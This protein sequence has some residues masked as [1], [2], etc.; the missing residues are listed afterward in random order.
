MFVIF[1]GLASIELPVSAYRKCRFPTIS[2]DEFNAAQQEGWRCV[3]IRGGAHD[4]L[5]LKP[6]ILIFFLQGHKLVKANQYELVTA[7]Q[8]RK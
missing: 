3:C 1:F 4:V 8:I 5:K 2:R 7:I 6:L